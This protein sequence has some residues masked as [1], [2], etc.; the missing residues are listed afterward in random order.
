MAWVI[1]VVAGLFEVAMAYSLKMSHGFS[2]P[3]PSI[4]F[5]VF[6]VL[7]FGLLAMGLKSLE[8][9]TAYAVWT[10]IGAVGTASLGMLFLGDDVSFLKIA[11]IALILAGVVGLN[12]AGG[13]H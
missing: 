9:G 5:I 3:L 10:G 8:V 1:I 7:S 6:A 11:S 13:G 4:G 12:L 2:V